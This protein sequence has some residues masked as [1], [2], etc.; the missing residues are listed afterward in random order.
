MTRSF[1][2]LFTHIPLPTLTKS[3]MM[4]TSFMTF[5]FT[6]LALFSFVASAPLSARDVFV[7]PVLYP[8]ANVVWK[9][10]ATHNVT[11]YVPS[12]CNDI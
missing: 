12:A 4:S 1:R 7:P 6:I 2:F 11:W 3:N 9:A 10:G 8:G 5:L